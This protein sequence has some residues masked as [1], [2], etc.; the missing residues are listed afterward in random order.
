MPITVLL[1]DD[2][3]IVREGVRA[4]LAR[5][6]AIDVVAV[7]GDY[8]ELVARA[9][10]HAPQVVV[11]D[12]RMPPT[13]QDEGIEGAREVRRRLP[14]TAVVIL[15]Q[16]DDPEYAIALLKDGA[17]GYAYL[18]KDRVADGDRLTTAIREVATGGSMLDPEIV[19]ALVAPA[20]APGTLTAEQESLL[21]E[22]AAGRPVKAIAQSL[23]TTP[24]AVDDAIED[25]F[26]TLAQDA[27]A[28][29]GEAL[30]RL[31]QLHAA[32]L[33]REEQG[34]T[35]S[36]LLPSGLAA[37]LKRDRASVERT[38]RLTVTVLMS[39]V[40]G[41]TT[42]SE[43]ADPAALAE[44]LNEHRKVM[45][46]AV[47]GEGGTVMQYIG[48]AVMAVFGAPDPLAD[49]A[50]AAIRAA[51]AMHLRQRELDATWAARGL[52]PFPLGIGLSTGLVAAAMLGSEERL[53]YTVVGDTVNISARLQDLARPGGTTVASGGTLRAAGVG[54]V[55]GD[56]G[57][58]VWEG[59][60][61]GRWK[62]LG[63]LTVKGRTAPVS[64][65]ALFT[66]PPPEGC[67]GEQ[68]AAN[69]TTTPAQEPS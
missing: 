54:A 68:T 45:N 18:L 42:I 43:H 9:V 20:R 8:E 12:I 24:E 69:S 52:A 35:L 15:S 47:L 21:E 44:Q 16:Y 10:E 39:D 51:R 4:L 31:R 32:I 17:A 2:N 58:P 1:A 67:G 53:E 50:A 3:L 55:G 6:E 27:S 49:H 60:R 59:L 62:P 28:G 34:L 11:T 25:L 61:E 26:L 41:Y 40:R 5:D 37:K 57:G 46:A 30:K 23:G 66:V 33:Q 7:A 63:D 14:G 48:D 64:A 56:G 22:V 65:Y 13:F 19:A 29:R 38:E 36:R